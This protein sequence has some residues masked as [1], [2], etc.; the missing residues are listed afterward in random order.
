MAHIDFKDLTRRT[1][2]DEMF[3]DKAFNIALNSKYV[4]YQCRLASIIY[5]F[6]DKKLLLGVSKMGV[7]QTKN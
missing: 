4:W 3:G 1:T 7:S 5:K 6:F 2:S